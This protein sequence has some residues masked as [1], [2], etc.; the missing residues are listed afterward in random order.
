[1]ANI[2]KGITTDIG[3]SGIRSM[4]I[5]EL[6]S[7]HSNTVKIIDEETFRVK[8]SSEKQEELFEIVSSTNADYVGIYAMGYTGELY[9]GVVANMTSQGTKTQSKVYYIQSLYAIAYELLE[10]Y[11]D[12]LIEERLINLDTDTFDVIMT[13]CIPVREHT[14]NTDGAT[15]LKQKLAGEYSIK[16]PTVNNGVTINFKIKEEN[17][18]VLPEG[19]SI[20]PTLGG[21]ESD[22][23]T[24]VVDLGYVTMDLALFRGK[25]L[26]GDNVVSS[27]NAGS[28]LEGLIRNILID[29]GF[30]RASNEVARHALET[31]KVKVGGTDKDISH[32]VKKTKEAFVQNFI[33]SEIVNIV[34]TANLALTDINNIVPIGGPMQEDDKTGSIPDMILDYCGL[35]DATMFVQEGN[36]RHVNIIKAHSIMKVLLKR[37]GVEF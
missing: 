12:D 37:A 20:V 24:L 23:I 21:V 7:E 28:T 5:G 9:S 18:A 30:S 32:I 22:D 35:E 31:G 16:F 19:A 26:L 14:G 11:L 17:I 27:P 3:G 36:L 6:V 33:K 2:I 4:G 13:T 8:E 15:L 10:Y 1:M 34:N 25:Q 29:A